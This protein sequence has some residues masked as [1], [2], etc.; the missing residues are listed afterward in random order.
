MCSITA[1]GNYHTCGQSRFFSNQLF[2]DIASTQKMR[3]HLLC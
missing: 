1:H 2:R 3:P